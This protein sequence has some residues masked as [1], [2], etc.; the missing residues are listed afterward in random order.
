MAAWNS[1]SYIS[2][3][4]LHSF[5]SFARWRSQPPP[6]YLCCPR[7]PSHQTS[8]L[9]SVSQVTAL[10]FLPQSRP[11]WPYGTHPFFQH[12]IYFINKG[13]KNQKFRDGVCKKRILSKR[14][15]A[16]NFHT[17]I[18]IKYCY[19]FISLQ[20]LYNFVHTMQ[21]LICVVCWCNLLCSENSMTKN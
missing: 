7:P 8:S 6:A 19:G 14:F 9:T 17:Q 16:K 1:F 15:W 18:T 5:R 10:Q 4:A 2:T 20:R 21:S 11:F 13:T 3:R 12:G